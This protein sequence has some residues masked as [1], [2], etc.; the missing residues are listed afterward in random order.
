[1]LK[2]LEGVA[3]IALCECMIQIHIYIVSEIFKYIERYKEKCMHSN[4]RNIC[5]FL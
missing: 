1:M 3:L 2:M 5:K 4:D